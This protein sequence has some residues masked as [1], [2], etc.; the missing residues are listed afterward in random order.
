VV[1][2]EKLLYMREAPDRPRIL[3]VDDN[4]DDCELYRRY[5]KARGYVVTIASDGEDAVS[6]AL[7]GTFD[8]VVLDIALPKLD[9]IQ[10]LTHL[11]SYTSTSRLQVITLSAST[12]AAVRAAALDAGA[13][14]ALE[15]PLSPA[16]LEAAIRAFV[17][18]GKRIRNKKAAE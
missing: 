16:D 1:I 3:I 18:R 12:G 10:V 13:D 15:K 6:R 2:R 8:L 7:N 9:G 11:R 14:L 17:E 5:L 4:A